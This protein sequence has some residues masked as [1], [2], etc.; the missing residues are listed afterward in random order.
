VKK[1]IPIDMPRPRQRD[2]ASF[3]AIKKELLD[4]FHLQAKEYFSYEI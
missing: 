3:V 1:S 2:G 4:E